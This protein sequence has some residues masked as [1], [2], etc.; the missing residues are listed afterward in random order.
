MATRKLWRYGL[1]GLA[2]V[3]VVAAGVT[4]Y[5]G[6]RLPPSRVLPEAPSVPEPGTE[7]QKPPS[8]ELTQSGCVA[9]HRSLPRTFIGHTFADW[10]GSLHARQGV[11]CSDCHGGDST[12]AQLERAHQGL[13]PS[14]DSQS[15]L[16]FTKI[17]ATCGRC[18]TQEFAYFRESVHY[19]RLQETGRGPNCVTCHGAM[20]V[21]ILSPQELAATCTA[22][23]NERLGIRPDEP[24]KARFL[25]TLIRQAEEQLQLIRKLIAAKQDEMDTTPAL[26]L[27]TQAEGEMRIIQQGW[28][29]FRL[30]QV[31]TRLEKAWAQA[32]AAVAALEEKP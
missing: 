6:F 13:R 31:E 14:R 1:L 8:G 25:L 23:H 16:Y 27:L 2:L 22:C 30:E 5:Y 20:A 9:C 19:Q 21:A 17:P 4:L 26:Q 15:P 32:Q 18:H 3:M 28:H 7:E 24:L 12:Q 29:T 11:S 10:E